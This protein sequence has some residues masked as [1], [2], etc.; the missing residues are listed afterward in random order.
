MKDLRQISLDNLIAFSSFLE[1][2]YGSELSTIE[3]AAKGDREKREK[4]KKDVRHK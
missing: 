3:K 4:E 1:K 2:K